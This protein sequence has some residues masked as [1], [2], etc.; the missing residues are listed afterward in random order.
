MRLDTPRVQPLSED[1]WS[2]EVR[3]ILTGAQVGGRGRRPAN[4]FTTLAR[5]PK[6][7]RRWLVFGNHVLFK[8][9]LPARERELAI[10]R[11]GWLCRSAYEF[12]QHTV[13]GRQA[14]LDDGEI[15]RVTLGPQAP[16]W[17]PDDATLLRAVDELHADS[18]VSDATW[19]ALARRWSVEQILDLLFAVGQYRLVSGVLNSLGVQL[20]AGVPGFP[21][22]E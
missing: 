19:S 17:S 15:R 9:T 10:L 16:G 4:I 21:D 22:H 1:Q 11:V 20:D 5:H 6:L 3:E 7:L 2:D 12:G 18:F 8:S 14:G 13:I